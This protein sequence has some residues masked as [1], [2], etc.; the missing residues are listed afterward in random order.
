MPMSMQEFVSKWQ[1][2]M[3]CS[4]LTTMTY[5]SLRW[6]AHHDNTCDRSQISSISTGEA[7]ERWVFDVHTDKSVISG[8]GSVNKSEKEV[9][10]E[11]QA[12]IRQIT[13]SVTFLPLLEESCSFDLLVYTDDDVQACAYSLFYTAGRVDPRASRMSCRLLKC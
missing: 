3:E 8:D 4:C 10:G 11:I 2:G 6:I 9:M 13:A 12:I 1:A 7:L 5:R